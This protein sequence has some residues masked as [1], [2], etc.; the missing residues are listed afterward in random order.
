MR[1]VPAA[2]TSSAW[3][4]A[5]ASSGTWHGST[6]PGHSE[7]IYYEAERG[8][9]SKMKINEALGWGSLPSCPGCEVSK[10]FFKASYGV[11]PQHRD[12]IRKGRSANNIIEERSGEDLTSSRRER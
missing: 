12:G 8:Q 7:D 9:T 11:K 6:G 2:V 3:L 1:N 4:A 5:R 10:S